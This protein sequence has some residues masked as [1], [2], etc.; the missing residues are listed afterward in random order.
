MPSAFLFAHG[1]EMG[2][3]DQKGFGAK[4][5]QDNGLVRRIYDH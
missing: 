5:R 2:K 4:G 3:G 1:G